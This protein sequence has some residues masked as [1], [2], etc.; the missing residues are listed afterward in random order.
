MNQPTNKPTNIHIEKLGRIQKWISSNRLNE[1]VLNLNLYT[2][3]A[4]PIITTTQ[5]TIIVTT[6]ITTITSANT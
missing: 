3:S 6:T 5:I 1:E 2:Q 4:I